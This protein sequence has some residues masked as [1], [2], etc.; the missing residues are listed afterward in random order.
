MRFNLTP[1]DKLLKAIFGEKAGEVKD[2]SLRVPPGDKGIVIETKIYA[3]KKKGVLNKEKDKQEQKRLKDEF[4]LQT[5]SLK[6][7]RA[8]ELFKILEDVKITNDIIE[9]RD[10]K[11]VVVI[12][13]GIKPKQ[14]D[15]EKLGFDMMNLMSN[16][17]DVEDVNEKVSEVMSDMSVLYDQANVMYQRKRQKVL[18]GDE[19]QPGILQMVKVYVAKK[20]KI[21]IGDKMAG[22]HG[23]KG[24][25]ARVVPTEDLPYLEDGTP[26]DI[27]LNP[28]GVPSRMNPGQIFET[29][30]G[31]AAKKAWA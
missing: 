10:N 12:K 5:N 1:E 3:R 21:Q 25:V 27:I 20:R 19:L 31:W 29:N 28:L 8:K 23:N 22:R 17:T 16:W 7:K 9:L 4:E 30:L 13:A 15:L 18:Y 26:V 6:R 11:K 2:A 14:K 24:I